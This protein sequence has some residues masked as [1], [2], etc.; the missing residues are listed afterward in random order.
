MRERSDRHLM[1]I[2]RDAFSGR[3]YM[4][5]TTS[6]CG[7]GCTAVSAGRRRFLPVKILV[8]EVG[9]FFSQFLEVV[10]D[11]LEVL[12]VEESRESAV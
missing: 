9:V 7:G 4:Y 8:N 11:R 10:D 6:P 1:N 12:F 2:L 3:T 5:T